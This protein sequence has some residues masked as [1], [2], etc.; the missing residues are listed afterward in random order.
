MQEYF[1]LMNSLVMQN[2]KTRKNLEQNEKFHL[3]QPCLLSS[4][5]CIVVL[6]R[7]LRKEARD[8]YKWNFYCVGN[9]ILVSFFFQ[10]VLPLTISSFLASPSICRRCVYLSIPL[11]KDP[12]SPPAL[13]IS[14]ARENPFS[15]LI[16]LSSILSTSLRI[17]S[18]SGSHRDWTISELPHSLLYSN[19]ILESWCD[20]KTWSG[21]VCNRQMKKCQNFKMDFLYPT[22]IKYLSPKVL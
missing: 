2:N 11:S 16:S 9:G 8:C 18:S 12:K 6:R 1:H 20:S 22:M 3:K 7:L 4:G 13:K 19:T 17:P 15:R 21:I 14:D 5:M 10:V